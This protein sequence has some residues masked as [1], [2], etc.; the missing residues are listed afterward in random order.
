M[1]HSLWEC[2][3]GIH[4][5]AYASALLCLPGR[6]RGLRRPWLLGV[7]CSEPR[8]LRDVWG[9]GLRT[10]GWP[11]GRAGRRVDASGLC[12]PWGP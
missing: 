3:E 7:A 1:G 4:A 9:W 5:L 2:Q 12:G 6:L 10:A 8:L 11:S